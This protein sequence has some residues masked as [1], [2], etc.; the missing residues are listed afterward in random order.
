MSLV[1]NKSDASVRVKKRLRTAT[2]HILEERGCDIHDIN[3]SDLTNEAGISRATFY[4]YY[5]NI[6][7]F[8]K[9]VFAYLADL[10]IKQMIKFLLDGRDALN[11]NCKEKNLIVDQEDRRLI[12]AVNTSLTFEATLNNVSC[13]YNG[14]ANNGYR[15]FF[16]EV[17]DEEKIGH[18]CFFLQG[19]I[20]FLFDLFSVE[21]DYKNTLKGMNYVFDLYEQLFPE[22]KL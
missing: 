8:F 2:L 14:F 11:E 6:D 3:V 16:G 9:E 17:S 13:F 18:I 1:L 22:S 5:D 19:Y 12:S 10:I 21:L 15:E 4:N 7:I 20:I